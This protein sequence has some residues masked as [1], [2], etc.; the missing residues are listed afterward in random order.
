MQANGEK[1]FWENGAFSPDFQS[2][3]E[4]DKKNVIFSKITFLTVRLTGGLTSRKPASFWL[5]KTEKG[6]ENYQQSTGYI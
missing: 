5:L 3:A 4:Q 1:V 2:R 6:G